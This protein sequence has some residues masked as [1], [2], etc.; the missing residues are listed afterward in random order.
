MAQKVWLSDT[1]ADE[2]H[3]DLFHHVLADISEGR[4]STVNG[5]HI[6]FVAKGLERIGDHATNIAEAV[7]FMVTGAT[8]STRPH[9]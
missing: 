8:V 1:Q 5:V 4:G 3:D 2:L 6:L 9:P 7:R